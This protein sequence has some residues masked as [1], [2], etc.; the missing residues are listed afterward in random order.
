MKI[1]PVKQSRRPA[2]PDRRRARTLAF[3]LLALVGCGDM[4]PP[5]AHGAHGSQACPGDMQEPAAQP[6]VPP[7]EGTEPAKAEPCTIPEVS[8]DPHE[9]PEGHIG[10]EMPVPD[11][12]V[13]PEVEP[14]NVLGDMVEP[15]PD[16]AVIPEVVPGPVPGDVT[17]VDGDMP[18]IDGDI[19][20]PHPEPEV[21]PDPEAEVQ[22][23]PDHDYRVAG[24]MPAPNFEPAP[25][26]QP[27]A[28]PVPESADED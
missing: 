10:G 28:A 25:E 4:M 18:M 17:A 27:E 8:A 7:A 13:A 1:N 2:Y 21:T 5:Q 15:H 3:G 9:V 11:P 19:V 24:G 22:V 20:E 6:A 23:P 26:P 14:M 16:P 12:S